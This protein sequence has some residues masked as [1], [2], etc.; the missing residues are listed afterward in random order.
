MILPL[1]LTFSRGFKSLRE[2][3]FD[4]CGR[5]WFSSFGRIPSALFSHDV[6]VRNTIYIATKDPSKQ[7][8]CATTRLHRW[9]NAEREFLFANLAYASCDPTPFDGAVPKLSSSRLL[10]ALSTLLE[11]E[12]HRLEALAKRPSHS[13]YFKKTAYNW[14]TV[15]TTRPP[16]FGKDGEPVEQTEYGLIAASD[17]ATQELAMGLANTKLMFL[18]WM[19]VG[20]DFHVT[21]KN[22]LSAPFG[23]GS[24]SPKQRSCVLARA[25][26]LQEAMAANVDFKLNAGKQIGNYNLRRC[27]HITDEIDHVLLEALDLG[28]LRDEIELEH[29]LFVRTDSS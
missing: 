6:R 3:L 8:R 9:F 11:E 1:S 29:S 28:P 17:A 4:E 10:R 7:V 14:L 25:P 21:K 16:A 2:F 5:I 18:W 20:D 13:L 23:P 19:T 22:L 12:P 26:A 27:R 15:C 24:L